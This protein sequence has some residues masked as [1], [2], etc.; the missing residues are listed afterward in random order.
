MLRIKNEVDHYRK[1]THCRWK[2]QR[3]CEDGTP[4]RIEIVKARFEPAPIA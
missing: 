3:E 2:V 1:N 4:K